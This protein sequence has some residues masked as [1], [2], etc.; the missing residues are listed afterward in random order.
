MRGVD[1][2][3]DP[4]SPKR[5]NASVKQTGVDAESE[6]D[7]VLP[8]LLF[9]MTAVALV[10]E[11]TVM[12]TVTLSPSSSSKPVMPVMPVALLAVAKAA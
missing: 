10:A 9:V 8:L 3:D 2:P 12:D 11:D 6:F 5:K 7:T 1:P 4:N